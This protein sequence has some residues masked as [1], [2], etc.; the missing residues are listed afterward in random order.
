MA[1]VVLA[2]LIGAGWYVSHPS[3]A[4][5]EQ[6]RKEEDARA[7]KAYE[8]HVKNAGANKNPNP[9]RNGQSSEIKNKLMEQAIEREAKKN[10]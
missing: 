10:Q 2:I 1:I 8:D 4:K 5:Q 7:R 3:A 6:A 9:F